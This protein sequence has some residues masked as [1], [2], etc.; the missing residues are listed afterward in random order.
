[1]DHC[2]TAMQQCAIKLCQAI[3]YYGA[4]T[5]EFLLDKDENFYLMEMNTRLQ[6][7][8]AV[9][10]QITGIDL[11]EQQIRVAQGEALQLTQQA[12]KIHGHSIEARLYA[13]QCNNNFLPA[14]G[15]IDA[16]SM[17]ETSE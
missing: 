14:S 11:V 7:E 4:G 5:L 6:V 2:R 12:I 9:S 15:N 17:P 16:I 10:E 3:N 13:E 8:H 1:S